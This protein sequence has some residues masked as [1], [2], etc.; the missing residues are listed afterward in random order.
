MTPLF[1][2]PP[3]ALSSLVGPHRVA[4]GPRFERGTC[5]GLVVE[6]SPPLRGTRK[7]ICARH[8]VCS[9]QRSEYFLS[10]FKAVVW[11]R[12]AN[13]R[14]GNWGR[15]RPPKAEF[16][17][18]HESD[19]IR[20]QVGAKPVLDRVSP[21]SACNV[22]SSLCRDAFPST[23]SA[24]LDWDIVVF[25]ARASCPWTKSPCRAFVNMSEFVGVVH[26][27][28]GR[29]NGVVK[30]GR[31]GGTV[32]PDLW[33]LGR[34]ASFAWPYPGPLEFANLCAGSQEP[35]HVL[36]ERNQSSR[37]AGTFFATPELS[38]GCA[39]PSFFK[40]RRARCLGSMGSGGLGVAQA[41]R[42]ASA[43]GLILS[44]LAW[45]SVLA[46]G[47]DAPGEDSW[48]HPVGTAS[49]ILCLQTS[50]G[51]IG[52]LGLWT[53]FCARRPSQLGVMVPLRF[54]HCALPQVSA[55]KPCARGGGERGR[56]CRFQRPSIVVVLQMR[57]PPPGAE[58]MRGARGEAQLGQVSRGC[59]RR[60]GLAA[61][62][63]RVLRGGVE[64][65]RLAV[66]V[67]PVAEGG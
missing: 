42:P 5:C 63:R 59:C 67:G 21:D 12:L 29:Q 35:L 2:R 51:R 8:W 43:A 13:L 20:Q 17:L 56:V 52:A 38:I 64:E 4:P 61:S 7:L 50:T 36:A 16:C 66:D 44:S 10:H 18:L 40:Q 15:H 27:F 9:F 60:V 55:G 48:K 39:C 49:W 57:R 53:G 6:V 58:T 54:K 31:S 19:R 45:Q 1:H 34:E 14:L 65:P 62:Q 22:P 37:L 33:S 25:G 30:A 3:T 28:M 26:L 41:F 11:R 47:D 32:S 24:L 23:P 46:L